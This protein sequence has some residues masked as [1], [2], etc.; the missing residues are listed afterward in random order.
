MQAVLFIVLFPL[1]VAASP[2]VPLADSIAFRG[3]EH[4]ITVKLETELG[5]PIENATIYFY[6]EEQNALLGTSS[7]NQTGH[8]VFAW[9]ISPTHKL[10]PTSLNATFLGDE[11][12][13]LLPCYV[14]ILLTILGQTGLSVEVCGITGKPIRESVYPDQ[15]LIFAVR[16]Q[17]DQEQ[18]LQGIWVSL[19]GT[20]NQTIA[21]G[22]TAQNGVVVFRHR[23]GSTLAASVLFKVR[24]SSLGYLSGSEL[25]LQYS[26]DKS[27]SMF[28]GC[29]SFIKT[30]DQSVIVGRLRHEYG[31]SIPMARIRVLLDGVQEIAQTVADEEGRFCYNL[32]HELRRITSGRFLTVSYDGDSSHMPTRTIVGLIFARTATP[33]SQLVQVVLPTQVTEILY[34]IGLVAATCTGVGSAY[35]ALRIKRATSNIVSH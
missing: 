19:L 3:T 24:S 18:P 29:P 6:H 31:D 4:A 23:L 14:P 15:T 8:A 32:D 25:E 33:F 26:V 20:E 22:G 11:K 2:P 12:R 21:V 10:G 27:P 9:Q 5:V 28:V 7:T 13:H 1:L 30:G 34:S 35:L 17:D 16:V